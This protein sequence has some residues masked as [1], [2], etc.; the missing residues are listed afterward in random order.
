MSDAPI[1]ST[2]A[3]P[4]ARWP[5]RL[6]L[7]LGI[8]PATTAPRL[9]L[10][11][12]GGL[13]GIVLTAVISAQWL[14]KSSSLPF[15][16]APMGA[17]A[18]LL[19][20]VPNSPLAQPWAIVGGNVLSA[21]CGILWLKILPDPMLAAA[22][23]VASAIAVMSLARCLHP[24]GG[25]C[26]LT[27][28]IGGHA[29][30]AAGW[31]FAWVPVGLNSVLL[32]TLGWIYHGAV[33]GNYPHRAASYLAATPPRAGYSVADIESV[34]AQYDELIDV[35]PA[36]LDTL[37]RQVEGRAWRRLHGEIRCEQ[38]MQT[39][40]STLP[41]DATLAQA[42]QMFAADRLP[43][44]AVVDASGRFEGL[45]RIESLLV[46]D[47][48]QTVANLMDTSPCVASPDT[49]IDELLPLL[50]GGVYKEALIVDCAGQLVGIVGQTDLLCAVWRGHIA[51]QMALGS[52]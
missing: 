25:A 20:A 27:A 15:L 11:A 52:S 30:T 47:I 22:P 39:H 48:T 4:I 19:F 13:F 26:A 9:G 44:L 6:W 33:R 5:T 28:V 29:I 50:S 17:S 21:L 10:A 16:V 32:V 40:L 8:Q 7:W 3:E 34:L 14:G 35:S 23:A 18:V 41:V 51:E 12:F 2:D 24:P 46:G 49:V 45:I 42:Q 37:F 36:D 38:I 31:Q 43:V 1:S